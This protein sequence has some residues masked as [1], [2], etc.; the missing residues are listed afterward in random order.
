MHLPEGEYKRDGDD[1]ERTCELDH[2]GA[3]QHVGARMH[4]VPS[5]CSRRH[6]RSVV[7]SRA[8]KETKTFVREAQHAAKRGEN[9]RR[10][11]VEQEDDRDS[12]RDFLIV[13]I[14]NRSRCG[15]SRT[16]ANG[17][18]HSHKRRDLRGNAHDAAQDKCND[19][20]RRDGHDDNGQ[21]L[22]ALG[23]NLREIHAK[24]QQDHGIL[25]N[26]L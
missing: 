24:A 14:D 20:R 13:G 8:R 21:G 1:G 25:K 6:R 15:N 2:G 9:Q 23:Q 12:L 18:A 11:N 7:D 17:G 10:D 16:A 26:L 5:A 4:A 19:E 22:R 3:L